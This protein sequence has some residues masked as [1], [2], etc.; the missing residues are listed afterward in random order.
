MNILVVNG[1]SSSLKCWF[2][3]LS[4]ESLA[5]GA[6]T[7][8]W[9]A[10]VERVDGSAEMS[11]ATSREGVK[12]RSTLRAASLA[13]TLPAVLESLRIEEIDI[14]GHRIVHGGRAFRETTAITD[15]VRAAIARQCELAPSHNRAELEIIKQMDRI[16]K[17]GVRQVAVFDTAFH[18]TL[19]PEAYTYPGPYEWLDLGIRRY[20]FHGISHQYAARRAAE[21]H[22][23]VDRLVIC[24]LGSGC[25]LAAVRDGKCIDTTMGFTPL[26]GLMMGTRSG[27]ID[28]AIVTYLQRHEDGSAA[29]IDR[30]LYQ[31]SGLKGVS[32]VSGDM[33]EILR[34]I[35]DGNVRARL[36]FDV[37]AHRL[38]RETGAMVAL[39]GG[40]DALVF[41]GGVG[42]NCSPLRER[43]CRQF[44]FLGLRLDANKNREPK[45]DSNLA[46]S[47][48]A[49]AALVIHAEEEWEIA[50]QC[51]GFAGRQAP[52]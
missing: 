42:E 11:L 8:L 3:R 30:I 13:E 51:Y 31:E 50:R 44:E 32:G 41:T 2:H 37:Y 22:D 7:P 19:A 10:H 38:C 9:T 16:L 17:P 43:L 45:G 14:V 52:A 4:G 12:S 18:A 39:L 6:P 36:A 21:L 48:S 35:S 20:G 46:A 26:D 15:E 5:A 40:L 47:D 1:G 29:D 27:S 33:R 23:R 49:L 34:A 24:H 25:S 28:P